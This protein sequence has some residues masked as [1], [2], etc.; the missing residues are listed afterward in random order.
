MPEPPE[1]A[2]DQQRRPD[3]EGAQ[4]GEQEPAPAEL[5]TER[6]RGVDDRAHRDHREL[7][8]DEHFYRRQRRARGDRGLQQLAESREGHD[9]EA[10]DPEHP[11]DSESDGH[12]DRR[13]EDDRHARPHRSR[14]RPQRPHAEF[15][16]HR[17]CPAATEGPTLD[18]QRRQH[19]ESRGDHHRRG[20]ETE[21]RVGQAL[22]AQ[23]HGQGDQPRQRDRGH[24]EDEDGGPVEA[25]RTMHTSTLGRTGCRRLPRAT[26]TG[27][28]LTLAGRRTAGCLPEGW[29]PAVS[30]ANVRRA[31]PPRRCRQCRPRPH[32]RRPRR[33]RAV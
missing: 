4:R 28:P 2:R 16:Q 9:V 24:G 21:E 19:A 8:A 18:R 12:E 22:A 10:R 13:G 1:R 31:R 23:P 3:A 30:I 17:P 7:H 29:H 20:G 26:E 11:D 15:A 6:E 32:R 33:T 14:G 25:R 5:L 27:A